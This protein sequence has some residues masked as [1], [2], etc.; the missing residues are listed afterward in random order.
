M[1]VLL[2]P[3][4]TMHHQDQDHESKLKERYLIKAFM[5][6]EMRSGCYLRS[7]FSLRSS[8]PFL[9]VAMGHGP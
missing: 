1:P 9:K 2:M 7:N 6:G 8:F 5:V 3:S 4:N